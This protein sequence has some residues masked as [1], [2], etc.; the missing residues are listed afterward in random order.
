[1]ANTLP[2]SIELFS[3]IKREWLLSGEIALSELTRIPDDLVK[4]DN[5][6]LNYQIQF[7]KSTVVLGF[8]QILIESKLNL[9]CQRSLETFEFPIKLSQNIGFINKREDE[10][11][12]DMHVNPAWVGDNKVNPKELLEDE[13]LMVIPEFPVKAGAVVNKRYQL[14]QEQQTKNV[15]DDNPFLVLKNLK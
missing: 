8:A 4:K 13:I 14:S 2:D 11:V 10:S 7:L 9:I 5:T 6:L 3:A 12:L 1:M 15:V